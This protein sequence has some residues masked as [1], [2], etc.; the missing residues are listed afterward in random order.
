MSILDFLYIYKNICLSGFYLVR[1][2][3]KNKKTLFP[4]SYLLGFRFFFVEMCKLQMQVFLTNLFVL[5][6]FYNYS[7]IGRPLVVLF[8][9]MAGC[10]TCQDPDLILQIGFVGVVLFI[11]SNLM[12]YILLQ[13]QLCAKLLLKSLG[14]QYFERYISFNTG[15]RLLAEAVALLKSSTLTVVGLNASN[16]ALNGAE[17]FMAGST[18]DKGCPPERVSLM[19]EEGQLKVNEERSAFIKEHAPHRSIIERLGG[20]D[21]TS[22]I[23]KLLSDIFKD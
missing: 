10:S 18:F 7:T 12:L 16:L 20:Q 13:V 22:T 8:F 1:N 4:Y 15:S 19:S 11:H 5:A 23:G 6:Y 21:A 17:T 3:V 2:F 9:I 14:Y